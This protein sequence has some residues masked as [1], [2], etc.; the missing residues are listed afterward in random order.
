MTFLNLLNKS[1]Y[2]NEEGIILKAL[3]PLTFLGNRVNCCDMKTPLGMEI[4]I[5][6]FCFIISQW[7]IG[8]YFL[9][10]RLAYIFYLSLASKIGKGGWN[11]SY[12]LEFYSLPL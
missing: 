8:Y 4:L 1:G 12:K 2:Y 9:A 10:I 6:K 11:L 7:K 3:T 5:C